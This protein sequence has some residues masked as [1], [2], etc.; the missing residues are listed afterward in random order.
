MDL[1][2]AIFEDEGS[3]D[4]SGS[5]SE[6][7]PAQA[8]AAAPAAAS[9]GA[10][11]AP[12]AREAAPAFGGG[13]ISAGLAKGRLGQ[14]IAGDKGPEAVMSRRGAEAGSGSGVVDLT[15]PGG[16]DDS[17]DD[18]GGPVQGSEREAILRVRVVLS[19]L[20]GCKLELNLRWGH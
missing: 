9:P 15:G 14:G 8:A 20:R 1:F 4:E 5:D 17:S 13:L 11:I 18:E 19:I 16:N 3:S 12:D 7:E 10:P 2:K 6:K